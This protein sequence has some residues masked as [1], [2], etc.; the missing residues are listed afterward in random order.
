M[1]RLVPAFAITALL[2]ACATPSLLLLDGETDAATGQPARTG[3]VAVIDE[4]TG[5]DRALIDQANS[6]SRLGSGTIRPRVVD[7][8]QLSAEER[9]LIDGL[10][11]QVKSFTLYFLE[12]STDLAPG[13]DEVL[14]ALF[15]E[16]AGRPGADVQII[17]HTDTLGAPDDN[18]RLS[19]ERARQIREVL[20]ARGLDAASTRAAGRGERD[21]LVATDDAVREGRN[22]RV[23][24]LVR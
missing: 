2:S 5:S 20:V 17:G 22:R 3:A 21:L 10:P 11:A 19:L 12:D 23:E 18:D 16:I 7:P 14:R 24:V 9:A 8:A 1:I 13:S 15:A 6:R 4:T